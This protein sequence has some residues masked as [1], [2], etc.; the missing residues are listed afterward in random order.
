MR[1]TLQQT[2]I[3]TN[4]FCSAAISILMNSTGSI[5]IYN[6]LYVVKLENYYASCH[7]AQITI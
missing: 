3:P 6:A 4:S 2:R 5:L 7:Q 1:I